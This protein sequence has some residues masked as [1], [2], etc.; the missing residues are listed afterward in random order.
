MR[1]DLLKGQF[2]R[3]QRLK[4]SHLLIAAADWT[5]FQPPNRFKTADTLESMQTV[6]LVSSR[7]IFYAEGASGIKI[8]GCEGEGKDRT[9]PSIV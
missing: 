1:A 6:F 7:S 5:S 3:S 9:N 2:S 4:P 8:R